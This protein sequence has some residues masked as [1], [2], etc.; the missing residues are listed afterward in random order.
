MEEIQKDGH[1]PREDDALRQF[2]RDRTALLQN[3]S[4]EG[5]LDS[6]F[7]MVIHL[8]KKHLAMGSSVGLDFM[9]LIQEGASGLVEAVASFSTDKRTKF[10]NWA[11]FHI[12]GRIKEAIRR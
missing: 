2:M 9:D 11:H 4:I 8:A 5:G 3:G 6:V 10:P 12:E 1:H 7:P